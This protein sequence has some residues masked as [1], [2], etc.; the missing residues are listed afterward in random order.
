MFPKMIVSPSARGAISFLLSFS[1]IDK[2]LI[3]SNPLAI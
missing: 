1:L 2:I 3:V